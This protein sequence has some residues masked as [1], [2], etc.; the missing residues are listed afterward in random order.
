M[1]FIRIYAYSGRDRETQIKAAEAIIKAASD[2][3]GAP[4]SA[5]TVTYDEVD[6]ELWQAEVVEAI[7]DPL[8]DKLLI[9]HGEVV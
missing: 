8:K 4:L 5:F 6:Q 1:P 3:M 7:I 2:A 9:D